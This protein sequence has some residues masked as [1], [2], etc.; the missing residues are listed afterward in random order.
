MAKRVTPAEAHA[1]VSEGWSY[2]DVRTVAELEA[3][4]PSGAFHVPL[5]VDGPRGRVPN[6]RFVE[7]MRA[8][9]PRHDAPIVVGCLGATR[10]ARA[11]ELL[12]GAGYTSIA[13]QLAG[14]GGAT[15]AFGRVTTPGWKAAGLPI[16]TAAEPGR[17]WAEI[18]AEL[19]AG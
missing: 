6:E 7:A 15:D 4:H 2:V 11:A 8:V 16:A 9:F 12:E 13:L 19:G 5:L 10:S 14:W 1:L 3:G 18:L 17:S